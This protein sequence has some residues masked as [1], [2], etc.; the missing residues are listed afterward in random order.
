MSKRLVALF[1]A[2][3]IV[4]A[5]CA[6]AATTEPTP[7][8]TGPV[9][10]GTPAGGLAADQVLTLYLSSDDPATLD[11]NAAQDNVS[12]TVLSATQRGLLY[13]DKDLNTV[14][15]LAES[16]TISP[17]AKTW[18]FKLR[19]DAKYSNGDTI[20]AGD[21]VFGW[22]R[23]VDVR[24]ANPYSY[25]MSPVEGA[26]EALGLA[27]DADTATIDAALEG[28]GVA[29]PDDTTFIVTLARPAAYFGAIVA[30]WL[31]V[32]I[33]EK[34]VNTPKFTEAENYVASGPFT[35]ESWEHNSEIVLVP[36]PNW[37][38]DVKPTLTE[39][40]LKIGGDPAAALAAYEAG[41]YDAIDTTGAGSPEVRRVGADPNLADQVY[42]SPQL[43]ITYYN[44]A[45]CQFPPEACPAHPDIPGGAP[46]SNKEF[47]IAL[48]QAVNKQTFID[49]TFGG[50]GLVANTM[51]MPG[52]PGY[53]KY[54]PYP[55]DAAA[56]QGHMT[57]ALT[58]LGITDGPDEG[59]DVTAGDIPGV[60][61]FG[62]NK[63][64]GHLPRVA[65]LAEAWRTTFGFS[66]TQFDFIGVDFPTFLQQRPKGLYDVSR[67]GWGADFAS[68]FNQLDGLF[69]CGGGNN[70]QQWCNEEFDSLLQQA[71]T[72][73][74]QATAA[75]LYEQ[76]Q[77]LM[78]DDAAALFLR[79]GITRYLVQP[80]L[81]N[82]FPTVND[83]IIPGDRF[84][85]TIQILEH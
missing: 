71:A 37:Y 43:A 48:T 13:F 84:P 35:I 29:A 79:F 57:T 72:E 75:G 42:D 59:T 68:A 15:S 70:D 41:D 24:K 54:D 6:P 82:N 44:F 22:K 55:F 50:L 5:A 80:Y 9:A 1:G 25:V 65:F 21:L 64:A 58:E 81:T 19:P 62:Y 51:V 46:T 10:T 78:L 33:Q 52:L 67:N 3:L 8:G 14:P 28:L 27:A 40:H 76:A 20:V 66:E 77:K 16:F 45:T 32:P 38:G 2:G 26:D 30:M 18:T 73:P 17:D 12:L 83:F 31:A 23:L 61:K 74:D 36:N 47:R 63:D 11:P 34:W 39:I 85:E 49:L 60:L 53:T 69:T 7:T 56:A 4:L